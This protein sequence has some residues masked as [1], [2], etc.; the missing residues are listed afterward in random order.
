MLDLHLQTKN[1]FKNIE[2]AEI[3]DDD[4]HHVVKTV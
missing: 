1:I 2:S 3:N 4:H